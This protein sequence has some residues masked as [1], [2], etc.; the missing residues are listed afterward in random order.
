MT[1]PLVEVRELIREEEPHPWRRDAVAV[2][3]LLLLAC[4]HVLDRGRRKPRETR[5]SRR[6]P[7]CEARPW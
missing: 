7:Q 5:A 3:W 1:A 2:R 4:G 6:C